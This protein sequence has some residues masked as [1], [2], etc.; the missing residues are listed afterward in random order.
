MNRSNR[1]DETPYMGCYA[2][3]LATQRHVVLIIC[4][5]GS[6]EMNSNPVGSCGLSA[7]VQDVMSYQVAQKNTF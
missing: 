7:F 4:P 2:S 1:S 5:Q 6:T 3:C